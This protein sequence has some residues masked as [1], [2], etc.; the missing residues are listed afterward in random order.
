MGC[1]FV[2]IWTNQEYFY[3][4]SLSE[5]SHDSLICRLVHL[6]VDQ[7]CPNRQTC[8]SVRVTIHLKTRQHV[9]LQHSL[10]SNRMLR[11]SYWE[12]INLYPRCFWKKNVLKLYFKATFLLCYEISPN[13]ETTKQQQRKVSTFSVF[14]TRNFCCVKPRKSFNC[15]KSL[16]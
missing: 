16:N 3:P 1:S 5:T 12:Y 8:D 11:F 13:C 15:K 14:D 7:H 9:V 10:F 4:F 2:K 6:L